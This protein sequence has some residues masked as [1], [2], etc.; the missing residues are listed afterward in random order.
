MDIRKLVGT[1]I[2]R[3]RECK[4][5]KQTALAKMMKMTEQNLSLIENGH[6]SIDI[7][8]LE[9]FAKV[10][11]VLPTEFFTPLSTNNEEKLPESTNVL[12]QNEKMI[13]QQEQLIMM[14]DKWLAQEQANHQTY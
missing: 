14:M 13:A 9:Q 12:Q 4:N 1:H 6:S 8:R 11:E 2:K 3:L 10:L 5:L 7:T